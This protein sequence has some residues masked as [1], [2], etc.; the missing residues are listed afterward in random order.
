MRNYKT[1]SNFN[2][3]WAQSI[4]SSKKSFTLEKYE[5]WF[6]DY[7]F[8]IQD[9]PDEKPPFKDAFIEE[10]LSCKVASLKSLKNH[11]S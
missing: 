1:E 8:E 10:F 5:G 2:S 3:W 7:W 11:D 4:N 9:N 6:K